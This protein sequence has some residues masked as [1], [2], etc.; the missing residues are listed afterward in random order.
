M[1]GGEIRRGGRELPIQL[2]GEKVSDKFRSGPGN[3]HIPMPSIPGSSGMPS[4]KISAR[5]LTR[6]KSGHVWV[7][8]SDVISD[9]AV[10]PGSLVAVADQRGKPL[11]FALYSSSSQI[12]IRMLSHAPVS[13]LPALIRERISQAIAYRES[14]VHDTNA[15]RVIFSEADFL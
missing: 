4:V 13:D 1:P 7:Y 5:G 14:I 3:Y 10:P 2:W 11:G 15:Y 9:N 6:L 12:A 8:R